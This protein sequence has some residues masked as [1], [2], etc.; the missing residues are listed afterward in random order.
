MSFFSVDISDFSLGYIFTDLFIGVFGVIGILMIHG[1]VLNRLLT[2]F[3]EFSIS[4]IAEKRYNWVFFQFYLSF[5]RLAL[6]HIFEIYVWGL[7]LALLGYLP[8]LVKA[9]IFAGSCYTTIGF[10]DDVLP[11]GRKS[12]A[13]YIALSGFFCLAWT[14]S[15]MIDM[16]QT[17]K[18]AWRKK[19]EG[20]KFFLL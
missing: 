17:Y 20:K 14:T 15:A 3:D 7:Y 4:H 11:S 10:V 9:I 6:V 13:F 12:L 18:A 8:N 2:R 1:T 16:T 19:Y 5:I